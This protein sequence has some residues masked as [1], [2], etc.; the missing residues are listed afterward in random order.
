MK[1]RHLP[2]AA[3]LFSAAT[4]AVPPAPGLTPTNYVDIG[5]TVVDMLAISGLAF[6]TLDLGRAD[7]ARAHRAAFTPPAP[8]AI[9]RPYDSP[10]PGGGSVSV[11]MHD[12]DASGDLSTQDRSVTVFKSCRI[13]DEVVSGSSEFIVAAHRFEGSVEITELEFRFKDIGTAALRW[14]GPARVELRTD[15]KRGTEHYRVTYRDL[16]VVRGQRSM[17]WNFGL[18]V[19]RPPIGAQVA[20]VDGAMTIGDLR[21]RLRQDEPFAIPSDGLPRSGQLT[22]SDG[23]GARLEVE[24]RRWRYAYRLFRAGN[25]SEVPDSASQSKPH[26]KH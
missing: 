15:L 9:G 21:L 10:C 11:S 19:V 25:R 16:A 8:A 7:T 26:G 13:D 3:A 2:L 20:S 5:D 4:M 18:D 22:A 23:H 24:A 14:T 1:P 6:S 12:R 17:R